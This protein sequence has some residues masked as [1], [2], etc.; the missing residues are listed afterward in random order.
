MSE[1]SPEHSGLITNWKQLLTLA[2][3]A[4]AVP[5]LVIIFVV[6]LI[7]GGLHANP[8]AP[9]MSEERIAARIKPVGDVNL[10][11]VTPSAA[12]AAS[13]DAAPAPAPAAAAQSGEQV[14][15]QVCAMCHA[16]GLAGAPKP[17]DTAA[18]NP[19]VAQGKPV[20]YEHSLKGIRAMPAKGG[21]PSLA[22]DEVIAAVDYMLSTLK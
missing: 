7:T 17:G 6:K 8:N 22:D 19:R 20:L 1:A 15:Q 12:P 13:E 9:H 2:V 11:P 4:F 21:N 14:Y 3:L 18:W 10:V 5:V 16:S